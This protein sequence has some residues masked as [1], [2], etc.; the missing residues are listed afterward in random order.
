MGHHRLV[1]GLA[2]ADGLLRGGGCCGVHHTR[3]LGLLELCQEG[4]GEHG[5]RGLAV[6][7]L[8]G[9]VRSHHGRW[10]AGYCCGKHYLLLLVA[11]LEEDT[12]LHHTRQ[13]QKQ[14]SRRGALNRIVAASL[15]YLFIVHGWEKNE[16][17]PSKH[18]LHLSRR[19]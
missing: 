2:E 10:G 14:G 16:E 3:L 4:C 17:L 7:A 5:V 19:H 6:E 18:P 1:H 9:V 12:V 15:I 13:L 8:G 11:L